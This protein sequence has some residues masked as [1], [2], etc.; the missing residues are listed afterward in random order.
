M[1][2]IYFNR[3]GDFRKAWSV[4][5]GSQ[6]TERFFREVVI[7]GTCRTVYDGEKA[8]DF[9]PV[10]YIVSNGYWKVVGDVMYIEDHPGEGRGFSRKRTHE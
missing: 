9:T 6:L 10:A 2:R 4:D 8:N 1:I 5:F 7:H 3:K